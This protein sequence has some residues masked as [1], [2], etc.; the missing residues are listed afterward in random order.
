MDLIPEAIASTYGDDS[1]GEWLDAAGVQL[2]QFLAGSGEPVDFSNMADQEFVDLTRE[3]AG[4]ERRIEALQVAVAT[5]ADRRSYGRPLAQSLAK[6]CG[7]K[8]A[9]EL[10]QRLTLAPSRTIRARLKMGKQ[11]L[12]QM[13]LVG[14][15]VPAPFAHVGSQF[16][17]GNLPA[18]TANLILKTL[19]TGRSA[20][21]ERLDYAERCLAE[22]ATGL[23]LGSGNQQP[24]DQSEEPS[25]GPCHHDAMRVAC[26]AWELFLDPDGSEPSERPT[27]SRRGVDMGELR[28]GL[29]SL[30]GWLLPEVAA[31]LQTLFDA[32]NSPKTESS[33]TE[34]EG[35]SAAALWER[36]PTQKRHDAFATVLTAATRSPDLPHL[37]GAPI[38]V[39]VQTTARALEEGRPGRIWGAHGSPTR[40][41]A[42]AVR[43]AACTGAL[44]YYAQSQGRIVAL[45]NSQRTFTANQRRAITVRDG[46]CVI[47][48]CTVPARWCEI[49]HVIPHSE[50]G[51]THTDNGVL[52][53]YYHHRHLDVNGWQVRTR[54]GRVETL[55]PFILDPGQRWRAAT[56]L[57]LHS[58]ERFEAER[59]APAEPVPPPQELHRQAG[60]RQTDW[61]RPAARRTTY[62]AEGDDSDAADTRASA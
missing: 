50:G 14:Q 49:H 31:S 27:M 60:A 6:K 22:T 24:A 15:I 53:C 36:T 5:E 46:G 7:S 39:L 54:N 28:D 10:L 37:G 32:I 20:G 55:A 9:V 2:R 11:L 16:E 42:G 58:A 26:Q 3:I 17:A 45:G 48:G 35:G 47:P 40:I 38:T 43:H 29:V 34:Q 59:E 57:H 13:S 62:P 44:Q 21:F 30:R 25:P 1:A 33:E 19:E 18:P 41:S 8:N 52:L 61:R 4:L 56:P 23:D 51:A 12:P